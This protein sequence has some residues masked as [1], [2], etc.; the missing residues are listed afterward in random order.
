[1]VNLLLIGQAV[2]DVFADQ[3]NLDEKVLDVFS[4]TQIGYLSSLNTTTRK[5]LQKP[6]TDPIFVIC[7]ESHYTVICA[8]DRQA[9]EK[10]SRKMTIDLYY[11]DML[12]GLHDETRLTI[13]F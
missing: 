2:S 12:A 9:L 6:P 3:V 5:P 10:A 4:S 13:T 8:T 11:Y 1:M 7:S